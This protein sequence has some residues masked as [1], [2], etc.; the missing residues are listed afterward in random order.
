M[1]YTIEYLYSEIMDPYAYKVKN[2]IISD[3]SC[4]SFADLVPKKVFGSCYK[5]VM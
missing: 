4:E 3:M 1:I 2:V 5:G